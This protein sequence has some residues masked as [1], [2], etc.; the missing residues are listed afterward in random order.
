[1]KSLTASIIIIV[2]TVTFSIAASNMGN[3]I[4]EAGNKVQ[5]SRQSQLQELKRLGY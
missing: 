3:K 4:E 2:T 5:T 1:M